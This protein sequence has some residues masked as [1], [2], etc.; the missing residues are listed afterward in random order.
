M[1]YSVIYELI[2]DLTKILSGLLKPENIQV[3][4]GK[5]KVMKIFFTGKGEMVLGGKISDGVIQSS[6]KCRVFRDGLQIGDGD[7]IGLKL[8]NEDQKELEK[9]EECGLKYRGKIKIAE[10]D[11]L[12]AWK[13]EK[14]MKTL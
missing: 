3:E 7:I 2:E 14:K 8:V 11:L 4:L 5:F 13:M 1:T 12:E 9:G 6:S 10:G